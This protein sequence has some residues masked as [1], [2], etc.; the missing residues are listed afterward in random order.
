MNDFTPGGRKKRPNMFKK[1]EE[2]ARKKEELK[3]RKTEASGKN[4][5][6]RRKRPEPLSI[7][8]LGGQQSGGR[9]LVLDWFSRQGWTPFQFQTD[10]W[11]AYL[12]GESGLIH[13]STGTGKTFAIWP[14]PLIEWLEESLASGA[15]EI[16]TPPITVLW[17]TPLRALAG[18]T[19]KSL[20]EMLEGLALNWTL[21]TRTGDTSASIKAR[22]KKELP[23]A[24]ITTPESLSLLLSYAENQK[25]FSSLKLVVV[26]EWHELMGTKRGT[27]T[28]LALARLRKINPGLRTWGMSATLGNT[29]EAMH[30]LCGSNTK[31]T[32]RITSDIDK[33]TTFVSLLPESVEH[34]PWAGHLG[35]PMVE[36]VAQTI[37]RAKTSLV[38]TNTRSQCEMWYQALL[39]VRPD[40]AGE[41]A[42]H[43]GSLDRDTRKFVEDAVRDSKLRCVVCTSSLD[44]GVDFAPV[45]QV[46][47]LGSAKGVARLLQRAGRSGHKPGALSTVVCV[48]THAFEIV[49]FAAA[50]KALAEEKIESRPPLPK[51]LDVLSQHLVTLAVGG[52]FRYDSAFEEIRSAY[53]YRTL[54][55]IEFDWV[56]NFVTKGGRALGAYPEYC[57]VQ[58]Y[59][60][61]FIVES[62]AVRQR[63]RMS[64]GT[65]TSDDSMN[66]VFMSGERIGQ[67]EESFIARLRPGDK[68]VF[69]GRCLELVRTKDMKAWVRVAPS[70]GG[71]VPRWMGGRMP[72]SSELSE[73]VR[74]ELGFAKQ[75]KYDSEEMKLVEP[76]LRLQ[77]KWS[78]IPD[79][80]SV[81]V[82]HMQS[83]EGYH[84]FIYPF[85]GR[86]VHEGLAALLA[87]RMSRLVPATFSMSI[88]DYGFEMVSNINIPI[89]MLSEHHLFNPENLADDIL[90]SMNASEMARRR[91][92]EIA[93]VA[94]LVFS[95]YPGKSKTS[96]QVQVSSG[97]LF[98]VF[99]EYDPDNL[100]LHQA[101]REV[102]EQQLEESRLRNAMR[103]LSQSRLISVELERASPMALPLLVES[104]RGKVSSET[105]AERV[106]RMQ[107]ALAK[108]PSKASSITIARTK[109]R[110]KTGKTA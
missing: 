64:I 65:I 36:Q 15:S 23:S 35:L 17:L 92:R 50:R 27:M 30:T 85:E 72:L 109:P 97:L 67:L 69:A 37:E 8:Q 7:A 61:H 70:K 101:Q 34:F 110:K 90:R 57:K 2:Q 14:A 52:G 28:E 12:K 41:I 21:E 56:I 46:L 29:E 83:R 59:D 79:E 45:E 86:L 63:H 100:L 99:S 73:A 94:G 38:F 43:H 42:L 103:R 16:T 13:S 107:L 102:L 18:D 9:E 104:W 40:W 66:V 48:P 96:R 6:A 87:Y 84:L 58:Q 53:S 81:L 22:Q 76:L 19:E 68:F 31:K 44:L 24:L 33:E 10:T 95:G 47:Q 39:T 71:T 74:R 89:E 91:F 32:R 4:L 20:R 5:K 82:E 77:E 55:D 93:R 51:P 25:M 11:D 108:K 54:S 98:D 75:G 62:D 3:R 1:R 26:D 106:S 49:E 88:N 78:Q 80:K 105:I 60:G